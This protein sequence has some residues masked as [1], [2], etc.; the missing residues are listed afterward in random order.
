MNLYPTPDPSRIYT[1]PGGVAGVRATLAIM[2]KLT[3][4]GRKDPG[5]IAVAEQVIRDC[6]ANDTRCEIGKLFYWVKTKIRYM[7]D[8]R[9]VEKINTPERTL[10]VGT[11]D[12]DD[13]SVLLAALLEASGNKTKF[14]VVGLESGE[15]EHVFV[16]VR[17][18]A[19]WLSLDPTVKQATLGWVP[20][21]ITRRMQ[22]H[23]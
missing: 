8:I 21:N 20:P 11:G 23:V 2:Q 9:D 16:Q 17:L 19:G 12:C 6:P 18:G 3:R 5:V 1:I 14:L 7:R 4:E 10:R 13:M 22:A 15:Y